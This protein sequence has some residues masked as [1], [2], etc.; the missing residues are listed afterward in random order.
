MTGVPPAVSSALDALA[1]GRETSA[2][3]LS[4]RRHAVRRAVPR[5]PRVLGVEFVWRFDEFARVMPLSAN[6]TPLGDAVAFLGWLRKNALLPREL[7]RLGIRLR[8]RRVR[9]WWRGRVSA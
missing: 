5:I 2:V 7:R 4:K 9:S 3:L 8:W 1:V 6:Q